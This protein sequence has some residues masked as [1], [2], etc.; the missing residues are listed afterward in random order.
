MDESITFVHF[1]WQMSLPSCLIIFIPSLH[2]FIRAG[3][4]VDQSMTADLAGE[5]TS[6]AG[7]VRMEDLQRILSAIQPSG[8][9]WKLLPL[10]SSVLYTSLKT[11]ILLVYQVLQLILVLVSAIVNCCTIVIAQ[12][13]V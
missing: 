7:P 6:A 5:V 10:S 4:L 12:M 13:F 2:V 3:N 1:V 9:S 11:Y 8:S